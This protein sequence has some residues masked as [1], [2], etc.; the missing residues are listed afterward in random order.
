MG[1]KNIVAVAIIFAQIIV[2]ALYQYALPTKANAT[3]FAYLR[4]DRLSASTSLPLTGT[5]CLQPQTTGT[6]SQIVVQFPASFTVSGTQG[7]WSVNTTNLPSG[8]TAW[9]GITGPS[10]GASISGTTVTFA[11]YALLSTSTTYC[12]KFSGGTAVQSNL[13]ST[14]G[15][16]TGKIQTFSVTQPFATNP[17]A[18]IDNYNYA[19]SLVTNPN[20]VIA[21]TA[22]VSASF[23]FSISTASALFPS[24]GIVTSGHGS[25]AGPTITVTASGNSHNGWIAW[26]Q[27]ANGALSSPSSGGS[28]TSTYNAGSATDLSSVNSGYTILASQLANN[29]TIDNFYGTT[30]GNGIDTKWEQIAHGTAPTAGDQ[31]L[32]TLKAKASASTPAAN[33]YSDTISVTGAGQF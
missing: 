31:F 3:N 22:T 9:P 4:L 25:V 7:N 27:S 6:Q 10:A 17:G 30:D 1:R 23:T 20:D 8:T 26:V 28:I 2:L 15:T 24:T 33:D 29:P 32:M 13:G 16:V 11:G 5:V 14:T 21:V 19:E 12:F 18:A